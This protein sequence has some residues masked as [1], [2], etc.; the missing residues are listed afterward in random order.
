M[1]DNLFAAAAAERL[2]GTAPLADRLR[3]RSLDELVGQEHLLG[4]GR[5]LRSLIESDRLSSAIL[6]GPPGTGKTT[7]ARLVAGTTARAYIQL[8]AVTATVKDV[9]EVI[10]GARDR[11]GRHDRGTILFLDEVHQRLHQEP[12][13]LRPRCRPVLAGPD[14]GGGGGSPVHRPPHGCPGVRGHRAG[15]TPW[16]WWWPMPPPGRW[17]SSACPRPNS[18][19]PTRRCTWPPPPSP[20]RS[21]PL[22]AGPGPM[23]ATA[24]VRC[25]PICGT[26]TIRERPVWDTAPATCILMTIPRVGLASSIGPTASRT[27]A[28]TVLPTTG[29]KRRSTSEWPASRT[30]EQTWTT[31]PAKAQPPAPKNPPAA[32]APPT[33][34]NPRQ[35]NP[36]RCPH[37]RGPLMA[38]RLVWFAAGAGTGAAR[39][40]LPAPQ[41]A[42]GHPASDTDQTGRHHR[43][44]GQSSRLR[45]QG[46]PGRGY[47]RGPALPGRSGPPGP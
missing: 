15:R 41:I 16:P 23:P 32:C 1:S 46:G 42:P 3:P 2:A 10:A 37:E 34:K 13:G 47:R 25:P 38:R 26:P 24:A 18:T 5:P 29:P 12:A 30:T 39:S 20:T 17:S 40:H 11:L 33:P 21:P 22:W 8:S 4:R 31:A 27:V 28:T 9:R 44:P 6:W 45:G 7:I 14:A 35:P 43:R 36:H 19:W